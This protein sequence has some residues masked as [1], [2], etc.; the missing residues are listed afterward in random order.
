MTTVDMVYHHDFHPPDEVRVFAVPAAAIRRRDDTALVYD[1]LLDDRVLRHY[2]FTDHWFAANCTLDRC[3]RFVTE[4]GPIDWCFNCD[5]TTPLLSVGRNVYTVDLA[6]DVLVGPDGYAHIV[7][8]E[9]DFTC[10][11]ESRWLSVEE[12]VGARRGMEELLCIIAGAGLV[13]Y[14]ERVFPFGAMS[15]PVVPP[16]MTTL[17]AAEVPLFH[18]SI[19]GAYGGR[20]HV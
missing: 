18:S 10:A 9:D 2:A 16:R 3:G 17:R 13:T 6:L 8:D 1:V 11:V 12:Q 5:I 20:K 7:Q 14:L 19:R 4:P 15:D